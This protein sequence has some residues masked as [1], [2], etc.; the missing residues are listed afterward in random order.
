MDEI[1]FEVG[2]KYEN[3]KGVFEVIA[4]R[5]DSMDIRWENG[6]EISTP[7]DL[8]QRIIERMQHEKEMEEAKALQKAKKAKAASSKAGKQFTGLEASDFS[9]TVSKTSWRGRGQLGGAVAQ[10]FKTKQFKFNSWAVL[11]KA[12]VTWLD[13]KRQKQS[14]LPLQLK[15]FARVEEDRLCFGL[16]IPTPDRSD[17]DSSDWQTF[18]AWLDR[19]ENDSWLKKQCNSHDL[20]LC[21]LGKQGFGGRLE[22]KKDQW[23]H[24]SSD[25]KEA[26]VDSVNAFL[27][28]AGKSGALD[29]RIERQIDK[30]AAI[31][32]KQTIASDMAALFETLMPLYAAVASA[33]H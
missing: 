9:N 32:K 1:Q 23:I 25:K 10:R 3:M 20:Y 19:P 4:I 28:T 7:I 16:S 17:S 33:N 6:E 8:Q 5:R 15:F 13:V 24:V 2:G 21:D 18:L 27:S 29:L 31:Q 30:T 12:E 14:N 26:A 22:V 11:R